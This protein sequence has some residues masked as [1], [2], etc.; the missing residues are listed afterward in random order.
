[1]V[2]KFAAA[3]RSPRTTVAGLLLLAILVVWGTLYQIDHGIYAAK[4]YLFNAWIVMI[5]G[6]VPFPGVK[7]TGAILICNLLGVLTLR[8]TWKGERAGL[9]LT[10]AG[11]LVL[12]A[13]GGFVSYTAR[14][15]SLTLAE[16]ESSNESVSDRGWELLARGA[17][18]PGV[19]A[20]VWRKDLSEIRAG[21][22]LPA[23]NGLP[24]ITVAS[25][26]KNCAAIAAPLTDSAS[27]DAGTD[28]L[29]QRPD[30]SDPFRN[31]PG[32]I[33]K[34]EAGSLSSLTIWGA[35]Q[36]PLLYKGTGGDAFTI[37]LRP[38]RIPL[39]LAV[40]LLDFSKVDYAGTQTPREYRS[41]IHVK[42]PSL[43]RDVVISMN[44]PYRYRQFT[45]YQSS[46]EQRDGRTS[47][48]FA[49][50]ENRGKALPYIAG[51]LMVAGLFLHFTI[52]FV[53][54]IRRL[55]GVWQ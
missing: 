50:V 53:K 7:L 28:S 33:L 10:H 1:M 54:Q 13:G 19:P 3:L 25:V 34:P 16:G 36:N 31:I 29:V 47:S 32:L 42:G 37:E 12:L 17:N 26:Y 45:F 2:K 14:E 38:R 15:S 20:I 43:D 49:V 39:P 35:T 21:E 9:L 11:A 40:T 4:E 5:G 46:Y 18:R 41:K 44:K 23:L 30:D 8:Q 24:R 51:L 48:T 55:W 27:T 52:L 6:I 22:A